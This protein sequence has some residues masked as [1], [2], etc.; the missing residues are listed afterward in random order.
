MPYYWYSLEKISG[1]VLCHCHGCDNSAAMCKRKK[2]SEND[3]YIVKKCRISCLTIV[4]KLTWGVWIYHIRK[5]NPVHKIKMLLTCCSFSP[6]REL[7]RYAHKRFRDSCAHSS[8]YLS[9]L[10]VS[11][12]LALA[13]QQNK[14]TSRITRRGSGRVVIVQLSMKFLIHCTYLV[15]THA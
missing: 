7:S 13:S 6:R 4:Q 15:N 8:S 2:T 11:R 10:H 9:L 5:R 3:T 14:T 1:Y 12:A